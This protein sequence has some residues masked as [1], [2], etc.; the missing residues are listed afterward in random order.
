[1]KDLIIPIEEPTRPNARWDEWAANALVEDRRV[2][3]LY[4]HRV[5]QAIR[6]RG[7]ELFAPESR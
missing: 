7:G 3:Q 4:A 2:A 1:M 6:E 5:E